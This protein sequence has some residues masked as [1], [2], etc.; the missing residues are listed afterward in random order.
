MAMAGEHY[1]DH[2]LLLMRTGALSPVTSFLL[3]ATRRW[4]KEN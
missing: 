2:Q 3:H 1:I 4:L